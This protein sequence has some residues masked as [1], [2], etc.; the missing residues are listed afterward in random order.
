MNWFS[1]GDTN[2]LLIIKEALL[3][4]EKTLRLGDFGGHHLGFDIQS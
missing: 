3:K 4:D 2:G 1:A